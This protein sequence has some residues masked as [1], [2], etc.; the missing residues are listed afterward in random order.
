MLDPYFRRSFPLKHLKK[1]LYWPWAE[2]RT[3]RDARAVLFTCEEECRLAR[4]SFWLYQCREE[5]VGY[6]TSPPPVAREVALAEFFEA[7][8]AL[9][10]RRIVLFLSRIHSKKGCDLL[11]ESFARIVSTPGS[12]PRLQLVLAG[13]CVGGLGERLRALAQ[14]LGISNRITWTGMLSGAQKW[15]A[16]YSAEVF[17]LPSHQENFGIAVAEAL[18]CGTPVLISD[19]VNIWREID[20]DAAGFVEADTL[21]G[22]FA[23]L[24]RWLALESPTCD[25]MRSAALACFEKRFD[26]STSAHHIMRRIEKIAGSGACTNAK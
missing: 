24:K 23:L 2:Y 5:V 11:I 10:D 12:D 8:P 22:T 26:I 1:W 15:G 19:Q 6:G 7:F 20:A 9:L 14:A 21:N 17:A 18:A 3:L 13:P 16:L 25:Q 4:Q